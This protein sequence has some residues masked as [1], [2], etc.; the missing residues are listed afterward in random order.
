MKDWQPAPPGRRPADD[1]TPWWTGLTRYHWFVLTVA[2]LGWLFDCLDQ[3]LFNLARKPAMETLLA[4]ADAGI[5]IVLLHVAYERG[6]LARM[7]QPSAASYL[8]EVESL[9]AAGIAVGVAPHSVRACS[10]A[11][12]RRPGR[13]MARRRSFARCTRFGPSTC[14]RRAVVSR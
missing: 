10:R 8:A 12:R 6:G 7:R 13:T 1:G 5:A 14:S 3:Q 9:R 2:A 11:W 4:A